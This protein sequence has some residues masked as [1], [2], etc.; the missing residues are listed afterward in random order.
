MINVEKSIARLKEICGDKGASFYQVGNVIKVSAH[1]GDF[2]LK[3]F[4]DHVDIGTDV[5]TIDPKDIWVYFD[6]AVTE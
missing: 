5:L 2:I 1:S 4:P 3:V 6:W